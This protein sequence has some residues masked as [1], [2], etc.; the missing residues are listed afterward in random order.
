MVNMAL[1]LLHITLA[2]FH[3]GVSFSLIVSLGVELRK[4][5]FSPVMKY[6]APV[7][8]FQFEYNVFY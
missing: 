5:S 3:L 2:F 7:F 1:N 4:S 8:W 6:F